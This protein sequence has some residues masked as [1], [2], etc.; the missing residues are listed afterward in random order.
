MK[1]FFSVLRKELHT[2]LY[3][4]SKRDRYIFGLLSTLIIIS[5]VGLFLIAR[6][7]FTTVM[8]AHGGTLTEGIVGTPRFINPLLSSTDADRDLTQLLYS[9]LVRRTVHGTFEPELAESWTINE[10]A[11]IYTFSLRRDAVFHDGEPVTAD[12]VLFT[13]SQAQNASLK[14]PRRVQFEGVTATVIDPQTIELQTPQ[15]Y[16]G[17]LNSLT[18]G[19][20]PAHIW[21]SITVEQMMLSD[22]NTE[23]IGSGPYKITSI[24]RDKKT[25]IP[26]YYELSAFKK[27]VHGKPFISQF[28]FFF[29]EN[30]ESLI[31]AYLAKKI[32]MVAGISTEY[33]NEAKEHTKGFFTEPLPRVFGVFFN[34]NQS[35]LFLEAPVRKTLQIILNPKEIVTN[36][37]MGH[38]LA[39]SLPLPQAFQFNLAEPEISNQDAHALLTSAGWKKNSET[40]IYEKTKDGQATELS[41]VLSTS[42]TPELLRVA[43]TIKDIAQENGIAITVSP[44]EIGTLQQEILRPRKYEALLFGHSYTHD[45]D[46]FAF[47]HSSQRNDP[48]LNIANYA[49][50]NVDKALSDISTTNGKENREES[51]IVAIKE[52]YKDIPAVFLYQPI[53]TYMTRKDIH[54][55]D[56]HRFIGNAS[57]RF[58]NIHTWHLRTSRIAPFFINNN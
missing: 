24:K 28:E 15:P 35:P 31:D 53:F 3:T 37:L 48:G 55:F 36:S 42:N 14:S 8:P 7:N 1:N 50:T 5:S 45:T 38:G 13:L 6:N 18:M 54:A 29:F 33:I 9:G 56:T 26:T 22:Y 25:G 10:D 51:Y 27:Y 58:S 4:L 30:E 39:S 16:A 19:I 11:T 41:F 32:D 46:M 40:G 34:H 44:S 52:L 43:E 20:L 17:F 57:D 21:K 47:W 23:P 12:D 2:T 49:N